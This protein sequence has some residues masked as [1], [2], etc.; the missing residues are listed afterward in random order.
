MD[1]HE[2]CES[3]MAWERLWYISIPL[4]G[5]L[6]WTFCPSRP[7]SCGILFFPIVSCGDSNGFSLYSS[8]VQDNIATS[9]RKVATNSLTSS[10][11]WTSSSMA[12]PN[13]TMVLTRSAHAAR[14]SSCCFRRRRFPRALLP[15]KA[16]GV[17]LLSS[18]KL[19][20]FSI[21]GGG[22]AM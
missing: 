9:K 2:I 8:N 3:I 19:Y 16:W 21:G 6:C 1:V 14:R 10:T 4:M 12:S 11:A 7:I 22:E 13:G 20:C 5:H 18:A 17:R 15:D